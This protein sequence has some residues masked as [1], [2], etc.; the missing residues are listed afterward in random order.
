MKQDLLERRLNMILQATKTIRRAAHNPNFPA[1]FEVLIIRS[2]NSIEREIEKLIEESNSG[3]L[4][5]ED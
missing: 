3:A 2:I 1:S 4:K 5:F